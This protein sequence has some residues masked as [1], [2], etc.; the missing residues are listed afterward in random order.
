MKK[1][2]IAFQKHFK[3][4]QQRFGLTGYK[5]YFKYEVLE[6]SF[7]Q[8]EAEAGKM[9]ATVTLNS[10][11]LDKDKPHKDIRRDAKHEA[12]HLLL[13]RVDNNARYRFATSAEIYEAEEE[14]V[15][16][17]EELI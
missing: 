17:L 7:A 15:N 2:F 4:Y 6:E 10:H 13:A 11:L 14:L 12:I 5:V 3:E 9:V 8:I 1:D 16:K